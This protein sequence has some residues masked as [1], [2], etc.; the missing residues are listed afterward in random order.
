[1]TIFTNVRQRAYIGLGSNIQN[2]VLQI[3]NAIYAIRT[4]AE[5]VQISPFYW[6]HFEGG[7]IDEQDCLNGVIE[8]ETSL[9]P[10]ELLRQLQMIELHQ[11]RTRKKK[12]YSSRTIDLDILFYHQLFSKPLDF[13][14]GAK[15][16]SRQSLQIVNSFTSEVCNKPENSNPKSIHLQTA[17]LT[18]PHPRIK[19]RGYVIYPL[20]DIAP[21]LRFAD[22]ET[23][24]DVKKKIVWQILSRIEINVKI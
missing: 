10:L 12:G 7:A 17:E 15:H 5:I 24:K 6:N 8:I 3:Q 21:T 22:G 19:E 13:Q 14:G 20:A 2:P 11:G 18:L 16:Y 9:H 4:F 1:M 23:V